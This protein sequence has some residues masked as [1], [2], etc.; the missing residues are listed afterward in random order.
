M[1]ES[2]RLIVGLGNPGE[3]YRYTRHNLGFLALDAFLRDKSPSWKSKF[4]GEFSQ[5]QS[6][7]ESRLFVKPQS[8]MNLSGHVVREFLNFYKW[9][10]DQ[11]VVIHD[12]ADLDEGVIRLKKGGGAGGHNGLL[13]IFEQIGTKDF[14]RIRVGVGKSEF[15]GLSEFLLR[16]AQAEL[17][18]NLGEKTS[19][20]LESLLDK[21]FRATQNQF[22]AK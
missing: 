14:Y 20:I 13:S 22:N 7:Q 3:K 4:K 10:P 21:G 2:I 15:E 11:M 17:L 12:E 8:F 5:D 18:E 16:P 1:T 6:G 9:S 19:E